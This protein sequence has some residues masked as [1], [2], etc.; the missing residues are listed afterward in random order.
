MQFGDFIALCKVLK[1]L[2]GADVAKKFF[3][4]NISLFNIVDSESLINLK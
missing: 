2:Y 3:T 1:M 4:K